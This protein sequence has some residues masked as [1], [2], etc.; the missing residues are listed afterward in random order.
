MRKLAVCSFVSALALPTLAHAAWETRQIAGMSVELYTPASTS[1]IGTGHSLLIGL[2]GCTQTAVQLRDYAGLES[3]ADEYGMVIA[4]PLVPNG[5]VIAG[6]WDYYGANHTRTTRHD[7]PLIEMTETLRDDGA[8]AIDPAQVY[9]AGF[10]AG[11]GEAL[12]L[13]CLAPDLYAG[14]GVA[15]GP[16]VGTSVSQIAQVGTTAPQAAT[17]CQTLAGANAGDFATQLAVTFTDTADGTVAQ[18]YA[19]VSADMFATV[20]GGGM[21]T[22]AFDMAS[23]PGTAPAGSGTEYQDADGDRIATMISSNGSGHAWP[24]GT[25]TAGPPLSYVAGNGLDFAAYLAEFFTANSRRA[26]GEWMPGDD[27]GGGSDDGS[28][29][30]GGGSDDAGSDAADDAAGS[31][32]AGSDD[33]GGDDGGGDDG[34]NASAGQSG[35]TTPM[36]HIEPS[37][38]QCA[39]DPRRDLGGALSMLLGVALACAGRRRVTS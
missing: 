19:Q 20:Y 12:V 3:T 9:L 23:L 24:A 5:G 18:G 28:G 38:C 26:E 4:L 30:S 32:E 11:G 29:D 10:S 14:I 37:G 17:A 31:D 33:G 13:G 2:H 22:A 1:P 39:A 8:L 16:A 25:G 21:Q 36:G 34:G 7:G 6:C 27:D 35:D 15:A